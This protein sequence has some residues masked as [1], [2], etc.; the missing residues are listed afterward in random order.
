MT[1]IHEDA[2]PRDKVVHD[3]GLVLYSHDER[4]YRCARCWPRSELMRVAIKRDEA[5]AALARCQELLEEQ[6]EWNNR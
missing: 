6:Y 5:V 4:D 1:V 2:A 3:E